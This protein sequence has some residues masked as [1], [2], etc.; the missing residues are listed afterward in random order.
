MSACLGNGLPG[1]GNSRSEGLAGLPGV[2]GGTVV[3][4]LS[5]FFQ[6]SRC[7]NRRN[8][9][10]H[11]PSA[12]DPAWTGSLG[13]ESSQ[14]W[15]LSGGPR[16]PKNLGR[17]DT[18]GDAL[19]KKAWVPRPST[20]CPGA[21]TGGRFQCMDGAAGRCP[22]TAP[23]WGSA[24]RPVLRRRSLGNPSAGGGRQEWAREPPLRSR[25]GA[26]DHSL[27]TVGWAHL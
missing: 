17:Q 18:C 14:H 24:L 10:S 23:S 12:S 6:A 26:K 8:G 1:R 22:P 7:R 21:L 9:L 15:C 20:A 16:Q 5:F 2:P 19:A 11:L 13:V 4:Q 27:G 3:P 25:R